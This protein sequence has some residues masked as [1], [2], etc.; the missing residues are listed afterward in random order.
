MTVTADVNAVAAIPYGYDCC[1]ILE[2]DHRNFEL[3]EFTYLGFYPSFIGL[4]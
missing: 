1:R 3:H 4:H 2:C